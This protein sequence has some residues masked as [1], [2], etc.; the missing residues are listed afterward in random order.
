MR[1]Y[2]RLLTGR[3]VSAI[4][5]GL[6][7]TLFGTAQAAAHPGKRPRPAVERLELSEGPT[8]GGS[9]VMITG[10]WLENVR[11]VRFGNV[12]GRILEEECEGMCEII[13]YTWLKVESPSHRAGTVNVRVETSTGV[14]RVTSADK[15]RYVRPT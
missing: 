2:R 6:A 15:Y 9:V 13:P 3:S 7:L 10:D 1:R 14:S 8:A 12:P 4:I 11:S 5:V